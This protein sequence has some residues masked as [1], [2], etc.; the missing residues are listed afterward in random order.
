MKDKIALVTGST[1]G[2]GFDIARVLKEE[3]CI[4]VVNG[5][6][7]DRV[8]AACDALDGVKG[9]V[10]DVTS[11]EECDR[12]QTEVISELG[13]LDIL[14]CNVGCGASVPPGMEGADELNRMLQLNYFSATNAISS[15]RSALTKASGSIVCI[16]SICG[17][18]AL[19]CPIGYAA[20][21]ATLQNYVS[22]T[23]RYLGRDGVR[24]N[25]VAPGNILF[26]GSI[27]DRKVKENAS[28][29]DDML[30]SQVPLGRLGLAEDVSSAVA[31]LASP[32][33]K[34]IT[35][36]TLVVDGGQIRR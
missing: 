2:I 31:F 24:I 33:A 7:A 32:V 28:L 35:G 21:K 8:N 26:D 12:L 11:V 10:A 23:S 25:C 17:L 16:S 3:G 29:V 36:S 4:A 30:S 15:F 18:E 20:A 14:I 19:G 27:W 34:F 13:R 1:S 6:N 22:N 9:F 5:R